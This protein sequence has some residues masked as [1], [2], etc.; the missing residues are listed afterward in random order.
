ML[1][2]NNFHIVV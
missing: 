2:H 1:H